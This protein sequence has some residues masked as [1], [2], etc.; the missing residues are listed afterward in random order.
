MQV[1]ITREELKDYNLNGKGK[2][3]NMVTYILDKRKGKQ[4]DNEPVVK[5]EREEVMEA[6]DDLGIE[7][8]K[9]QSTKSLK[10]LLVKEA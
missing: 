7:Y 9:N 1:N 10:E 4:I 6:L 3:K 5:T 2:G 8:K